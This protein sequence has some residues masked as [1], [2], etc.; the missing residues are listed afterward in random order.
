MDLD[1]SVREG[2]GLLSRLS[3]S[4]ARRTNPPGTP[5]V[6][7]D[8]DTPNPPDK[9]H[10]LWMHLDRIVCHLHMAL[11]YDHRRDTTIRLRMDRCSR[12]PRTRRHIAFLAN[13][14]GFARLVDSNIQSDT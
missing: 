11:D 7:F 4:L 14:P 12:P 2:T 1:S 5:Y 6:P 10:R 3:S 9:G 8:F 13:T